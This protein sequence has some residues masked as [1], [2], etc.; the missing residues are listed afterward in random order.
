MFDKFV[1][2]QVLGVLSQ[3]SAKAHKMR[4]SLSAWS[5]RRSAR[6]TVPGGRIGSWV[7]YSVA[8]AVRGFIRAAR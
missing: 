1:G 8:I 4:A 6:P 2:M 7:G 5:G 3:K